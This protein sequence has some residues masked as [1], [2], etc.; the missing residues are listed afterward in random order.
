M[1]PHPNLSYGPRIPKPHSRKQRKTRR[2]H[3]LYSYGINYRT[4]TFTQCCGSGSGTGTGRIRN[5]WPDPDPIRNR[6]KGS[7]PDPDPKLLFRIRNTAF[8]S[9]PQEVG[10]I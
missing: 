1:D 3:E 7:E 6:N 8:T 5:F 10:A 9:S 4:N 2:K